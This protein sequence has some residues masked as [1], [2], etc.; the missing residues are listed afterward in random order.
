M[1]V[2]CLVITKTLLSLEAQSPQFGRGTGKAVPKLLNSKVVD[3]VAMHFRWR[4]LLC[5]ET[6]FVGVLFMQR[7]PP[8]KANRKRWNDLRWKLKEYGR[9]DVGPK[10]W[11]G[12]ASVAAARS[13]LLERSWS[14]KPF[15][16]PAAMIP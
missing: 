2:R 16:N 9:N 5:G 14:G 1:T 4:L 8:Q 3:S 13:G 15:Q 10:T 6:G 11:Q 12:L 7:T